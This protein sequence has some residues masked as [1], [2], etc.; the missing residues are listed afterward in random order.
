MKW[1]SLNQIAQLYMGS[2]KSKEINKRTT[3]SQTSPQVTCENSHLIWSWASIPLGHTSTLA[4][5]LNTDVS[6][7]ATATAQAK[8]H[9]AR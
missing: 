2:Q 5:T 1:V 4:T 6:I 7:A 3:S 8:N 9:P